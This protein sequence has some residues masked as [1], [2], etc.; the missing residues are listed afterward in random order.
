MENTHLANDWIVNTSGNYSLGYLIY[1]IG[2]S[3]VS[4][5]HDYAS[6]YGSILRIV[7]QLSNSKLRESLYAHYQE[8][9]VNK[10]IE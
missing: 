2:N 10:T 1:A 7:H 6:G 9:F 5:G 8:I 4:E 3:I